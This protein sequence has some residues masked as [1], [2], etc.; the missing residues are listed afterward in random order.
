MKWAWIRNLPFVLIGIFTV[1]GYV[2]VIDHAMNYG[3]GIYIQIILAVILSF[4]TYLPVAVYGKLR[5]KLGMLMI[6]KTLCYVWILAVITF[7]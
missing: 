5:P 4:L 1:I 3:T 7:V 6:P 2:R